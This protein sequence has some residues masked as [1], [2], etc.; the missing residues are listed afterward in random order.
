[1]LSKICVE[2]PGRKADVNLLW[3]V[4]SDLTTELTDEEKKKGSKTMNSSDEDRELENL[5]AQIVDGELQAVADDEIEADAA[6]DNA[7]EEDNVDEVADDLGQAV[8]RLGAED[9]DLD[10]DGN[11]LDDEAAGEETEL[12]RINNVVQPEIGIEEVVVGKKAKRK[13]KVKRLQLHRMAT[14]DICEVGKAKMIAI[15][16]PATRHRAK[17][18]KQRER[19]ALH[20]NLAAGLDDMGINFEVE[21]ARI[22]P[23]PANVQSARRQLAERIRNTTVM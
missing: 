7:V 5:S 2:T 1:M 19:V 4:L 11:P 9:V 6:E 8:A 17:Q 14:Q 3:N 18:R 16:L 20:D 21:L 12:N 15:D 23:Q 22:D 10:D 13:V